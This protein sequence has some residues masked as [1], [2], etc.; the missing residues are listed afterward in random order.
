VEEVVRDDLKA[1]SG[2]GFAMERRLNEARIY[3]Y[4]QLAR[5]TPEELRQILG[6]AGR[7]AKV[8]EW[9]AQ[10]RRLAGLE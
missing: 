10:A 2:I 5:S 4:V 8:E 9:I 3:T 7:L 1:I 6:E